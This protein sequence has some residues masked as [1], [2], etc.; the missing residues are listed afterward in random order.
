[1]QEIELRFILFTPKL[2]FKIA[3][4]EYM[5]KNKIAQLKAVFMLK[6]LEPKRIIFKIM[7]LLKM[8]FVFA[9]SFI[10]FFCFKVNIENV[11]MEKPINM[12]MGICIISEFI[13]RNRDILSKA[14]I[15]I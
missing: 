8:Q 12:L 9:K 14:Q 13:L 5:P 1:M 3:N 7:R 2:I 10:R 15:P 4:S 6:I 11:I